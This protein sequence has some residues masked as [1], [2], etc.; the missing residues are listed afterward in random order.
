[1]E[2]RT[3]RLKAGTASCEELN[4][5]L[6]VAFPKNVAVNL[7]PPITVNGDEVMVK[8]GATVGEA[9][10]EAGERQVELVLPKLAVYKRY[11][12]QPVPVEFERTSPS[13]LNLILTGV[14][15]LSW[16]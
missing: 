7:L 9:I 2:Q 13:I 5:E 11:R 3:E 12:G 6:C 16:R 1:M 8:W 10:R 14:E 15:T 4:G